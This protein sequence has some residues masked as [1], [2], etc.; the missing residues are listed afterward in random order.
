[1]KSV[2]GKLGWGAP[3]AQPEFS[4]LMVCM[5]NIC[6][7]P[8]AEAALRARLQACGLGARVKVDSA[9]TH[10]YHV[11][12]PPDARAQR[13]G[14]VRGL[15]LSGL[16]ARKVSAQD[17]LHFD[18]VLA[19]DEDNLAELLRLA[20]EG[21]AA[22]TKLLMSFARVQRDVQEIPDPYY[23]TEAGF[24]RVL[25]LV[26]DACDGLAGVLLRMLSPL[27]AAPKNS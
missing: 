23:G 27:P 7:S 6:R 12:S 8:T 15:D 20:P 11:G 3:E 14:K 25:D 21:T 26:G 9:G 16:R 4:V 10:G 2:I 24:E 17:F 18:L 5:G 22:R 19:M 1:M 13:H